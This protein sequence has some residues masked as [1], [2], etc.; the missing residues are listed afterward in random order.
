MT[1]MLVIL[2]RP[3]RSAEPEMGFSSFAPSL[4][5]DRRVFFQ[6]PTA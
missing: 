1:A 4:V 5:G 6:Q 3:R 2:S